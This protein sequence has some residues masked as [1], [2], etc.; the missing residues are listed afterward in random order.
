MIGKANDEN[1]IFDFRKP[2]WENHLLETITSLSNRFKG[3]IKD[4][5]DTKMVLT[6]DK[7][8]VIIHPLWE[9]NK[10]ESLKLKLEGKNYVLL[11]IMD[12]SR[13]SKL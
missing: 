3:K 11:N 5:L 12:A 7:L 2:Y 9:S 8:F 13:K 10:I 4:I 1:F 6:S